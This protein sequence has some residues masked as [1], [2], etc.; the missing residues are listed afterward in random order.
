MSGYCNRIRQN[1]APRTTVLGGGHS[2]PQ[3]N[4]QLILLGIKI[5]PKSLPR[6]L[7][8]PLP[9]GSDDDDDSDDS[10]SVESVLDALAEAWQH[11]LHSLDD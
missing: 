11:I 2:F 9:S 1:D 8:Y 6:L 4:K 10:E 7:E 3:R 5:M